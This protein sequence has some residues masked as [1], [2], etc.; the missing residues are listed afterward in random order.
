[1]TNKV[2]K[3][4]KNIF[5]MLVDAPAIPENPNNP[6][7]NAMNKKPIDKFSPILTSVLIK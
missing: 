3:M 6:A 7:V 1:M 5:A 4:I 2:K